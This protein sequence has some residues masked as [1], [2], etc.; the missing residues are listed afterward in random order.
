MTWSAADQA[1]ITARYSLGDTPVE[2]SYSLE[3]DGRIRSLVFDRWGNPGNTGTFGWQPFGGEITGYRTFDGL[4]IPA[5]AS[6]AG[7][8]EPTAG[9]KA[10]SSGSRLPTCGLST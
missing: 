4:S 7:I 8:S 3:A 6:W 1:H 2:V 10:N 5:P 9:P